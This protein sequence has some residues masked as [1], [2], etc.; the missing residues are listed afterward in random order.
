MGVW[1]ALFRG[2]L[3]IVGQHYLANLAEASFIAAK[4]Y[5]NSSIFTMFGALPP[6]HHVFVGRGTQGTQLQL[7]VEVGSCPRPDFWYKCTYEFCPFLKVFYV[8]RSVLGVRRAL[9]SSI[10]RN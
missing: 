4:F 7:P 1:L 8:K 2:S 5:L 9:S 3:Q 6:V 10:D